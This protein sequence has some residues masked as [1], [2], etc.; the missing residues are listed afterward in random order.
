[1]S[2]ENFNWALHIRALASG[3]SKKETVVQQ[4][5]LKCLQLLNLR[6]CRDC[7]IEKIK[8]NRGEKTLAH[9]S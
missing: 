1:M 4:I 5:R 9:Q 3:H 8:Q 6:C 2:T 7:T